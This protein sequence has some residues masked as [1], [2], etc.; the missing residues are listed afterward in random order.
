MNSNSPVSDI[1][2]FEGGGSMGHLILSMDWTENPL[3]DPTRWP[4]LL[5]SSTRTM[6]L[7]PQPMAIVWGPDFRLLYNDAFAELL[8]SRKSEVLGEQAESVWVD[9]WEE[10]YPAFKTVVDTKAGCAGTIFLPDENSCKH[11]CTLTA[12]LDELGVAN[13]ILCI[14][15]TTSSSGNDVVKHNVEPQLKNIFQKAPMA[16]CILRGSDHIVETVNASMLKLWGKTLEDVEQKSIFLAVP[17][18][19]NQGFEELLAQVFNEVKTIVAQ[20]LPL[21]VL[22]NGNPTQIYVKFIFEP[23]REEDDSVS[24]IIA[25][26][27]E[28]TEQVEA[29]K[30]VELSEMR[31][32]LAIE[33]AALGSFEWDVH[34]QEF[35]YSDRLAQI[36]GY[37]SAEG[38]KQQDLINLIHPDDLQVREEAHRKALENGVLF[39]EVR[40]VWRDNSLHWI[41]LNG[42]ILFSDDHQPQKIV[43]TILDI[44]DHKIQS[45][46][47]ERKVEDRTRTLKQMN[48]EL[49]QSEERYHRMTD[50]IQDYAILLLDTSGNILNWNKG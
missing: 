46:I 38:I 1:T 29:R 49:Q 14:C 12:L 16:M 36:F 30:R 35:I 25:I 7:S 48:E 28:I 10:V 27:D 33:A 47:L 24:G 45:A 42:K 22:R 2:Y 8:T 18:A 5:K 15:N 19:A 9:K 34:T 3:G 32:K 17:E 31:H 26:A 39:Y 50:E 41:R 13:G 21:R 11:F 44:T 40:I 20:E 43:G 4:H 37:K 6:L 23:I